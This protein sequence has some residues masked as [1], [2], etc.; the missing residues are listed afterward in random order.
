[1]LDI[2]LSRGSQFKLATCGIFVALLGAPLLAQQ[3]LASQIEQAR[4]S[5]KPVTE[6]QVSQDRAKLQKQM[7]DVE[8]F[9]Q[10]ASQNGQRWMRYL[11]WDALK[12]Q[13]SSNEAKNLE[14]LDATLGKLNRNVSG[15][16]NRRFRRWRGP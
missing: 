9:V 12:E 11:Q 13:V 2:V 3:D 4:S 6:Q 8:Q 1:M 14:A 16:E 10:P 5:F 15:L 7:Q